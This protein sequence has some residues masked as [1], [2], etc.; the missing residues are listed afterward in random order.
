MSPGEGPK[1]RWGT[2][3]ADR[4]NS[5]YHQHMFCARLDMAVDDEEGGKGLQVSEVC[6]SRSRNLVEASI[7][8]F[9]CL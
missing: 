6:Q 5:Q 8:P 3:V 4:V 9:R 1:P 2:L 7:D